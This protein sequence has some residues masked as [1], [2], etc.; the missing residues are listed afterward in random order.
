[1]DSALTS[2]GLPAALAI[3]M[4]GLGLSLTVDDGSVAARRQC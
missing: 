2:V 1:M 3:I 4:F